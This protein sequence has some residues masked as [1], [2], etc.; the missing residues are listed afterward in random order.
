MEFMPNF[1][2]IIYFIVFYLF[3]LSNVASMTSQPLSQLSQ[4]LYILMR[5]KKVFDTKTWI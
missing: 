3:L 2:T 1:E 5:F 4:K